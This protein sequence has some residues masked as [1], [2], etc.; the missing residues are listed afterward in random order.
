MNA[1][2]FTR[3]CLSETGMN[4]G[5]FVD[6]MRVEAAQQLIDSSSR[7]LKEIADSCGFNLQKRCAAPFSGS[8]VLV[9]PNTPAASR[10][11]SCVRHYR[12]YDVLNCWNHVVA[13]THEVLEIAR[14]TRTEP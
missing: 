12:D 2:H 5:Q 11:H 6:R 8:S 14:W 9:Q 10:A 3:V 1:R 4:P 13:L 7:G